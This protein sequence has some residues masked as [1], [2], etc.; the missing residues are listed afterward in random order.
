ML[1]NTRR[2]HSL[3]RIKYSELFCFV[4]FCLVL[5]CFVCLFGMERWW[6]IVTSEALDAGRRLAIVSCWLA[7]CLTDC[8]GLDICRM[9]IWCMSRI[10]ERFLPVCV[11]VV[12]HDCRCCIHSLTKTTT[13]NTIHR[14]YTVLSSYLPPHSIQP[15]LNIYFERKKKK[16]TNKKFDWQ[17]NREI[18]NGAKRGPLLNSLF[19]F[20]TVSQRDGDLP[21][22]RNVDMLFYSLILR[23]TMCIVNNICFACVVV[24]SWLQ[25]K[26]R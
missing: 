4:L 19:L 12:L 15:S 1:Y 20:D 14:Y 13:T 9:L 16:K 17:K 21:A 2:R 6:G 8:T 22:Q 7:G 10:R 25:V 5:F 23:K 26:V 3:I 18:D 24:W 11:G